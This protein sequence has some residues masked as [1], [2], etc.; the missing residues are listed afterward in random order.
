MVSE[1]VELISQVSWV[2][3]G[4]FWTSF[5]LAIIT[6][7]ATFFNYLLLRT[8]KDPEVIVY[9]TPDDRRPSIINLVIENIGPGLAK[10]VT[11]K[12]PDYF[13]ADAFGFDNSEKPKSMTKGPLLRGIPSLGPG[14]KRILTWGQYGGLQ[15]GLGDDTVSVICTYSRDR[16][17]LPGQKK[18]TTVC[19]LDI[20]SF[21]AT[22]ASDNNWDKK[23]ANELEKIAKALSQSATGSKPLKIF[24]KEDN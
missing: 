6:V 14:A 5:V 8:Q 13:P 18:L 21:E 22:D 10:N 20:Q 1:N 19:S 17:G 23:S 16:I 11:F 2:E 15:K 7:T 12:I 4:I 3:S 24:L 9:A